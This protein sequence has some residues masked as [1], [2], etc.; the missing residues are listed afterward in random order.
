MACIRVKNDRSLSR[1]RDMSSSWALRRDAVALWGCDRRGN[2]TE[3]PRGFLTTR[4]ISLLLASLSGFCRLSMGAL[5]ALK[6]AA[7]NDRTFLKDNIHISEED[8]AGLA[9]DGLIYLLVFPLLKLK[10]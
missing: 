8:R 10:N 1:L 5:Q 9:K 6:K 7:L 4:R 3:C 2:F